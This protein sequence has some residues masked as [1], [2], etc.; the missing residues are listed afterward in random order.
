MHGDPGL[1]RPA[2]DARVLFVKDA[3]LARV[4]AVVRRAEVLR[5][6]VLRAALFRAVL[7]RAGLLRAAFLRA[8]P[9]FLRL[10]DLRA[11]GDISLLS[12]GD[13]RCLFHTPDGNA[14]RNFEQLAR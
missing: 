12:L 2:D 13:E 1:L 7:F 4:R 8:P 5:A 14:S 9:A 10:E 3:L 11:A 6:V